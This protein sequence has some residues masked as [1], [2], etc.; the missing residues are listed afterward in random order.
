MG[1]SQH[2]YVGKSSGL[3]AGQWLHFVVSSYGGVESV[4]EYEEE[5][6][7]AEDEEVWVEAVFSGHR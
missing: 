2:R 5:Q 1:S 7:L 4:H 3:G 6:G